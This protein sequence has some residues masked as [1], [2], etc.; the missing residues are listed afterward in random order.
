M[1]INIHRSGE[2]VAQLHFGVVQY[3]LPQQRSSYFGNEREDV[4]DLLYQPVVVS[5]MGNEGGLKN[6]LPHFYLL[7]LFNGPALD[8]Q[9]EKH[10]VHIR[11]SRIYMGKQSSIQFF[12]QLAAFHY[13]VLVHSHELILAIFHPGSQKVKDGV[14]ILILIIPQDELFV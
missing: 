1:L 11:T 2:T 12:R 13:H 5:S 10:R 3:S 9:I 8:L 14:D 6:G 7:Q 4:D